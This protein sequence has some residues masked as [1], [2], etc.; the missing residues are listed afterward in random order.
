MRPYVWAG[1]IVI[2]RK[3]KVPQVGDV[4][5]FKHEGREK[6]KTISHLANAHMY[7]E[8]LHEHSTDSHSFGW[9]PASSVIGTVVWPRRK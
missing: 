3:S 9:L 7:V 6:I 5:V 2:A 4:V 1:Q 8:G